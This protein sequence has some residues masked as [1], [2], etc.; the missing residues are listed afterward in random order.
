VAKHTKSESE[1]PVDADSFARRVEKK[2][3]EFYEK[4]GCGHGHDWEDWFEA[5]KAVEGKISTVEKDCIRS[6]SFYKVS[7]RSPSLPSDIEAR[8]G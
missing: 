7:H 5:E 1:K 8:L 4:R 2:A 3:H 6:E